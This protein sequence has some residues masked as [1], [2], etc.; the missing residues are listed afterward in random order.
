MLRY[1]VIIENEDGLFVANVPDLPRCYAE[2]RMKQ[3]LTKNVGE[4]IQAY[5]EACPAR[6]FP[7]KHD[8][9]V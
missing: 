7:K 5:I 4:A 1:R 2:G 6:R 9:A 8:F 3:E